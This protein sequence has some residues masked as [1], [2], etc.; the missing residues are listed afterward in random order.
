V[1]QTRKKKIENVDPLF[2]PSH[3]IAQKTTFFSAHHTAYWLVASFSSG[4]DSFRL[5]Q[6]QPNRNF[7]GG[8]NDIH[9]WKNLE[10]HK[11]AAGTKPRPY[12]T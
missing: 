1:K 8:T 4:Y 7:R 9:P 12:L 3:F 11:M 6:Q 2:F 10:I 5:L